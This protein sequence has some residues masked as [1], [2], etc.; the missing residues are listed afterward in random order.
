MLDGKITTNNDFS[1]LYGKINTFTDNNL[2]VQAGMEAFNILD[3]FFYKIDKSIQSTIL[4]TVNYFN[5]TD[6][7]IDDLSE[8][9][10]KT[11][12]I[13]NLVEVNKTLRDIVANDGKFFKISSKKAPVL[14]GL[15]IDLNTLYNLLNDNLVPIK[16]LE[17]YVNDFNKVLDDILNS[18]KDKIDLNIDKSSLKDITKDVETINKG[19]SRVTSK[20]VLVDRQPINKLVSN[21]RQL[22]QLTSNTIRLGNKFTMERLETINEYNRE[23]VTKL[24]AIHKSL[25][26]NDSNMVREDLDIFIEYINS[27]AKMVTSVAFLFYLYY[28]L[29]NML[30]GIVKIADMSVEDKNIIETIA[31]NITIGSKGIKR[32][33]SNLLS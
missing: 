20:T 26:N 12:N 15:N 17:T 9:T 31:M 33:A 14:L 5:T 6:I 2:K 1:S 16:N 7:Y 8:Y 11:P 27:I 19:L 29:V 28:Q 32:Y 3:K 23:I 24:D 10:T 18:K 13:R 25:T 22:Q 30:V 4:S 21:Y